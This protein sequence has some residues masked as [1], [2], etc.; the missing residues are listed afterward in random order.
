MQIIIICLTISGRPMPIFSCLRTPQLIPFALTLL[1]A[2]TQASGANSSRPKNVTST[3]CEASISQLRRC[4]EQPPALWPKPTIDEGIDY[5]EL[6]L[7]PPPAK[8]DAR[9]QKL[10]ILGERLF[11][12]PIL[13]AS[14][15][16]TC[17][18]CHHPDQRFADGR[19]TSNGHRFQEGT[20]NSPSLLNTGLRD[21]WFWDGR[22]SSLAE[23]AIE[24]M[25]N[26]IE[27]AGTREGIESRLNNSEHYRAEFQEI[28]GDH[29]ITLEHAGEA[30]ETWQG[31]LRSRSAPFD[32][33]LRGNRDALSDQALLGL[34]LFRTRARCANCHM[35]PLLSDKKFHNIGLTY[36]GRKLEDLGR[37]NVTKKPA[38]VGR[39]R[40][41]SLRDIAATG[42]YMH[43][44]NF[45][46]LRGI[47]AM[48]NAGAPRPKPKEHQLTDPL[49]PQTSVLL[50]PLNLE[51]H[52]L[53][54]LESFLLSLTSGTANRR[55]VGIESKN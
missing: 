29:A 43:T 38:D 12:D 20:R 16:L 22:A 5:Q 37:Y 14:E 46:H 7:I 9:E 50:K 55:V 51:K 31:T 30:L 36:Y 34:H 11:F 17:A 47:L 48:Y 53:D 26:P 45:P 18:S 27:M 42:P 24:P 35:G 44:G 52:E 8:P 19:R 3:D 6:G 28:F 39:F 23:Q 10:R 32:R 2:G 49:F 4:Y 54:A 40:T 1:L 41:S 21:T 15:Q 13:S 25:L 33:F